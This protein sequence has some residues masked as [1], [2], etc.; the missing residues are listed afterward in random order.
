MY[1]NP[2]RTTATVLTFLAA[3]TILLAIGAAAVAGFGW[4]IAEGFTTLFPADYA[5]ISGP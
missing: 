2:T 3:L 5:E 1:S 4:L